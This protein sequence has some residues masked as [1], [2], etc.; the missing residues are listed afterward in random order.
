MSCIIC[1]C[2]YISV[3]GF[4]VP[5]LIF[6]SFMPGLRPSRSRPLD[7]LRMENTFSVLEI[8]LII[9]CRWASDKGSLL[10]SLSKGSSMPGLRPSRY[11]PLERLRIAYFFFPSVSCWSETGRAREGSPFA[12][13][14]AA[15]TWKKLFLLLHEQIPF[16]HFLSHNGLRVLNKCKLFAGHI[17]FTILI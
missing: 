5:S 13:F 6:T 7:T 4:R 1:H 12:L 10:P 15:T 8:G 16:N 14:A 17:S 9:H 11:L 2:K 3:S